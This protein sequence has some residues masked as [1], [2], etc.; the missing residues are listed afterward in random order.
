[1]FFFTHGGISWKCREAE[2]N[3][4]EVYYDME[5]KRSWPELLQRYSADQLTYETDRHIAL[6]GVARQMKTTMKG[7]YHFG[8]WTHMPELLLWMMSGPEYE[9]KGPDAPS[10]SF[11]RRT[12]PK[13]YWKTMV[14]FGFNLTAVNHTKGSL[15]I[16]EIGVLS[17]TAP[18]GSL[19]ATETSRNWIAAQN[20]VPWKCSLVPESVLLY[21]AHTTSRPVL[22]LFDPRDPNRETAIGLASL[23]DAAVPDCVL[24]TSRVKCILLVCCERLCNMFDRIWAP[25]M[26]ERSSILFRGI[27]EAHIGPSRLPS[28]IPSP[29]YLENP[30]SMFELP[31]QFE[32]TEWTELRKYNFVFDTSRFG[33][34]AKLASGQTPKVGIEGERVCWVML[35]SEV[36]GRQG[37]WKRIGMGI[38]GVPPVDMGF[39]YLELNLV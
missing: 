39:E 28:A 31:K 22:F 17:T 36:E 9:V 4:R 37:F 18:M 25:I 7:S 15:R 1:M 27:D 5:E 6:E 2:W 13:F 8:V 3:K 23:D 35:V 16:N 38:L 10:W 30:V 11:A 34:E 29:Q 21:F 24:T 32:E 20:H 14:Q 19:V 12:G 26:E 33:D